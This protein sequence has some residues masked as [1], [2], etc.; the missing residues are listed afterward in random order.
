MPESWEEK[1]DA[2]MKRLED[3]IEEIGRQVEVKGEELGKKAQTKAKDIQKEV[4]TRPG[5]PSIFWGVVL[6]LIGL[7][8]LAG[9][10]GLIAADIP[11]VPL[12]MIVVGVYLILKH[13][14]AQSKENT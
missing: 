2:H 9:N 11:W 3:R 4:E 5:M 13:R 8:W 7:I 1:F 12:G 10:L 6:I 14:P